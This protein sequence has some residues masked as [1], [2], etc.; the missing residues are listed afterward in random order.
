MLH[1]IPFLNISLCLL[2]ALLLLL[3]ISAIIANDIPVAPEVLENVVLLVKD[4][5]AE[6]T[7]VIR[8]QTVHP[9]QESL[10]KEHQATL[11]IL[12]ICCLEARKESEVCYLQSFG[13]LVYLLFASLLVQ[14]VH[15]H[16]CRDY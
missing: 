12:K 8:F 1:L 6:N 2:K 7:T 9:C 16:T 3:S 4:M 10:V 15:V 11:L 14:V 13:D 5:K